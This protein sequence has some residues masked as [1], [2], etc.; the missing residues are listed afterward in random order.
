MHYNWVILH[1]YGCI[2]T[3]SINLSY[4]H[5]VFGSGTHFGFCDGNTICYIK[6]SSFTNNT[7]TNSS[8]I[9]MDTGYSQLYIEY[10]N[11]LSNKCPNNADLGLITVIGVIN[12]PIIKHSTILYNEGSPIFQS[13]SSFSFEL[14]NCTVGS[15]QISSDVING[16]VNL[17][18]KPTTSFINEFIFVTESFCYYTP[19]PTRTPIRTT[20]STPE[21]T[22]IRTPPKSPQETPKIT[23]IHTPISTPIPTNLKTQNKIFMGQHFLLR[24]M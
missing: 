5:C 19:Y 4:N 16:S 11:I 2:T 22:P 3:E 7:S 21:R 15:D 13:L 18:D 10:T 14:Y 12:E 9:I 23:P 6:Y 17:H 1:R 8:F 20:E 24:S